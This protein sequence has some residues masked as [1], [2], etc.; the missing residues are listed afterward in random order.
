MGETLYGAR[1][2]PGK[3]RSIEA[4]KMG[5]S[6][7]ILRI[8]AQNSLPIGEWRRHG[9]CKRRPGRKERC[10]LRLR[11]KRM[12]CVQAKVSDVQGSVVAFK[13]ACVAIHKRE[14]SSEG[15][16]MCRLLLLEA[17]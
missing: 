2:L 4:R 5:V 16:G 17:M 14:T 8:W 12:W 3:W 15:V 9:G 6:I 1:A 7:M 13:R 10:V 11:C